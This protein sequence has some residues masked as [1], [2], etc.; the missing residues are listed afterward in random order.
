MKRI[1]I[2]GILM[3]G[4]FAL[5]ACSTDN[6]SNPVYQQPD[7]FVLNT[8]AFATMVFDLEN[9]KT[10]TLTCTQPDYGFTAATTYSVQVSLNDTWQPETNDV[11]ATFE[12]LDTSSSSANIDADAVELDKAI[13]KLSKWNS[14]DDFDGKNMD[15]YV[16]LKAT[17]N[18][19]LAP[20]YSN[21]VKINV[22]PYYIELKDAAPSFFFLIG[23][24]V[25]GWD[26]GMKDIGK[27]LIPMSMVPDYEYDKKTGVGK[28][29]YTG[30]F[31]AATSS[32]GF[33]LIG[34]INNA[35]NW[36]EQW[37]NGEDGDLPGN[38]SLVHLHN[39]SGNPG[40]LGVAESGW[41]QID[42]NDNE[43]KKLTFT[44]L[45]GEPHAAYTSIQ[46]L[47]DFSSWETN[48]LTMTR[49][50]NTT[51]SWTTTVTFAE[52]GTVKFRANKGWDTNWG[53]S[54]L[55]FPFGIGVPGEGNIP[56]IPGTYI[57]TFNDI[58]GGYGFF[59]Q[60]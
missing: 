2:Y 50:G 37:G 17:V 5:T 10:M 25:G 52:N 6:D 27:S 12:E 49:I 18:S 36:N 40:H 35:I 31:E 23:N 30:Y 29:T 11:A 19:T 21:S 13:V 33:K 24:Y 34:M 20:V 14:E 44:K 57:V 32:N 15:I 7:S 46:L 22:L 54:A 28:F 38:A 59:I 53:N 41:Y 26:N 8:P 48:E 42:V 3:T 1:N 16:R 56:V 43:E 58:D 45:T 55:A 47:G 39:E 60:E 51:H 4:V 9:A